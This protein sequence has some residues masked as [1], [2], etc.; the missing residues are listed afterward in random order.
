MLK[1]LIF[2]Y[3]I[4]KKIALVNQVFIL[5]NSLSKIKLLI[6]TVAY[7]FIK[8][9]YFYS[10][11]SFIVTCRQYILPVFVKSN[12]RFKATT[13][14]IFTSIKKYPSVNSSFETVF[15]SYSTQLANFEKFTKSKD[16]FGFNY[17]SLNRI[18]NLQ[19]YAI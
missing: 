13:P 6:Q 1:K 19:V 4:F 10:S 15:K 5:Y 2:V 7:V 17:L 12:Q 11:I 16:D 18:P 14:V 9:Q 3:L 8:I